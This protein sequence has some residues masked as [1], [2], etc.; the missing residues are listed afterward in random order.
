VAERERLA[1][2]LNTGLVS[3]VWVNFGADAAAADSGLT[4]LRQLDAE[5]RTGES[6]VVSP[7]S[8]P[9]RVVGS[10]FIPSKAWLNKMRFRGWAGCFLGEKEG[11][12]LG[13]VE[14]ATQA[15]LELLKV[16]EKHGVEPLVESSVRTEK[17]AQE[18]LEFL[19][20]AMVPGPP[21]K[22]LQ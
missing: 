8:P 14:G 9:L 13:S 16:Y 17:E 11:E 22:A 4:Y 20:K 6:A 1:A 18:C 7:Q 5:L 21:Q 2:K 12:Y 3:T 15:T 10:L 19:D